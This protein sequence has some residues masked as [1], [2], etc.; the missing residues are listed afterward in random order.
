LQDYSSACKTLPKNFIIS[1]KEHL[2]IKTSKTLVNVY[3]INL[4]MHF[5]CFILASPA[6]SQEPFTVKR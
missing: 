4:N 1:H 2:A 3:L 5:S 6:K